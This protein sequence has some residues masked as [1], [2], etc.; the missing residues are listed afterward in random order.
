MVCL[1]NEILF[2]FKRE[3]NS[4]ICYNIDEPSGHHF[5]WDKSQGDRDCMIPNTWGT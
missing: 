1:Y 3:E 5:K 4:D 2:C